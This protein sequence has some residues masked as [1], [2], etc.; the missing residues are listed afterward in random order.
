M[1]CDGE[2]GDAERGSKTTKLRP[3][4]GEGPPNPPPPPLRV[5]GGGRGSGGIWDQGAAESGE[6]QRPSWR[7]AKKRMLVSLGS[8]SRRSPMPRPFSLPP[9][10][11]GTSVILKFAPLSV[12]R[13]MA[14]GP[15]E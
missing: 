13:R 8:M 2:P 6:V 7:E 1:L 10:V 9:M 11:K 15:P 4:P 5:G 3:A 14:A 12:E